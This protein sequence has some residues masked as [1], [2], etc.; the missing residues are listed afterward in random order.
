MKNKDF[1]RKGYFIPNKEL[2]PFRKN[3]KWGFSNLHG[4]III[5]PNYSFVNFFEDGV[6]IVGRY[7]NVDNLYVETRVGLISEKGRTILPLIFSEIFRSSFGGII[8]KC[9]K[10]TES[11]PRSF[12]CFDM[13]GNEY[14]ILENLIEKFA[15]INIHLGAE[16][17]SIYQIAEKLFIGVKIISLK[18]SRRDLILINEKGEEIELKQGEEIFKAALVQMGFWAGSKASIAINRKYGIIEKSGLVTIP[19]IY[20]YPITFKDGLSVATKDG[21]KG[22]I[23]LSNNVLVDFIYD[24]LKR[25]E[26]SSNEKAIWRGGIGEG[27]TYFYLENGE[28]EKFEN[29]L[30]ELEPSYEKIQP[31]KLVYDD[32]EENAALFNDLGVMIFPDNFTYENEPEIYGEVA[33]IPKDEKF[34]LIDKYGNGILRSSFEDIQYLGSDYFYCDNYDEKPE[35]RIINSKG[36]LI[37]LVDGKYNEI[38]FFF[39]R[40]E[41]WTCSPISIDFSRFRLLQVSLRIR[42]KVYIYGFITNQGI[43]CWSGELKYK[44]LDN[45]FFEYS[46]EEDDEGLDIETNDDFRFTEG[47]TCPACGGREYMC[48]NYWIEKNS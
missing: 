8:A 10:K 31:I 27:Y 46:L 23:D 34:I 25:F 14:S 28:V 7:I 41:S 19:F 35:P 24:E 42:D 33:I 47:P 17:V 37:Y 4:E 26:I 6:A 16:Y 48:C 20:D 40:A 44:D 38:K 18:S 5:E 9:F 43:E 11:E 21:K 36:E 32:H 3:N 30:P 12:R 29:I 2:I 13:E 22:I 45:Q 15:S 1:V 39:D